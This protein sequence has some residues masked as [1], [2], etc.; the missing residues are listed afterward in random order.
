MYV[1]GGSPRQSLGT[2]PYE[3]GENAKQVHD[4]THPEH[5]PPLIAAALQYLCKDSFW[6]S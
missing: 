3:E 5:L 2:A 6:V 1:G 4:S